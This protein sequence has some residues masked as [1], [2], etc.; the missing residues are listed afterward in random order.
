MKTIQRVLAIVLAMLMTLGVFAIG[1]GASSLE[2]YWVLG[3]PGHELASC[4]YGYLAMTKCGYILPQDDFENIYGPDFYTKIYDIDSNAS[5]A[6][7][8]WFLNTTYSAVAANAQVLTPQQKAAWVNFYNAFIAVAM[9]ETLNMLS[10]A[11]KAAYDA[12]Y[13]NGI[14]DNGAGIIEMDPRGVSVL[15][16]ES[17][18]AQLE[19]ILAS[20]DVVRPYDDPTEPAV[21]IGAANGVIIEGPGYAANG[22]GGISAANGNAQQNY[23]FQSPNGSGKMKPVGS[24][25]WNI[26]L[27]G[28]V[29][30]VGYVTVYVPIPNNALQ[31][32]GTPKEGLEIY[33][34]IPNST[35]TEM[36]PGETVLRNGTWYMK[37]YTNHFSDYALAAPEETGSG[38]TTTAAQKWWQKLPSFVQWLLRI[39]AF[40]WIWMK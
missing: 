39:F 28:G 29:Q 24:G 13:E 4:R 20:A 8:Q 9:A 30:P 18:T 31:S 38:T 2:P 37:F 40:G 5:T 27:A 19:A 22:A 35:S 14:Y 16:V 15:A 21:Q 17:V 32:N 6:D 11:N 33:Y 25:W 23:N 34:L 7:V 36:M 10:P 1:A 26:S 12:V 3:G